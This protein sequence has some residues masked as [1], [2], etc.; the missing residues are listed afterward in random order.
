MQTGSLINYIYDRTE[1]APPIVGMGAT[2]LG[3]TDRTPATVIEVSASGKRVVL[4]DDD[5]RRTDTN[6]MSDAQSYE[7][8]RNPRGRKRV[9]TLRKN[10]RWV[11][12]GQP[13]TGSAALI[14]KRERYYDFSF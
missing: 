2:V 7:Y 1:S 6:G 3:W 13:M 5:F 12:Q 11:A 8:E 4:Q 10:G 9:F 14:G